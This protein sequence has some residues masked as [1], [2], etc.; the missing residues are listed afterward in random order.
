[1]KKIRR[2]GVGAASE[3][4]HFGGVGT[5]SE[6]EKTVRCKALEQPLKMD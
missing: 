3:M 1:M 2:T 6:V 5:A 4:V